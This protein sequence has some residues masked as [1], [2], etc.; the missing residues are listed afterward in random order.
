MP[1]P[2]AKAVTCVLDQ[3]RQMDLRIKELENDSQRI[4]TVA[5]VVA[6]HGSKDS[7]T[8]S[9]SNEDEICTPS[10]ELLTA[11]LATCAAEERREHVADMTHT[12]KP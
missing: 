11:H 8:P 12:E 5:D 7:V 4:D 6:S 3:V 2:V 9:I 1:D 10:V